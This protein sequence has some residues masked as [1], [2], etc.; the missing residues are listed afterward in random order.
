MSDVSVC[1]VCV[2]GMLILNVSW[3]GRTYVGALMDSTNHAWAPPRIKPL[4]SKSKNAALAGSAADTIGN[5]IGERKLRNGK[6]TYKANGLSTSAMSVTT[7][8][9]AEV[10]AASRTASQS[11]MSVESTSSP[12]TPP[13]ATGTGFAALASHGQ[14]H[15][16]GHGQANC[17]GAA[18]AAAAAAAGA[19]M[20][21]DLK[22]EL[23]QCTENGCFKKFKGADGLEY[24]RNYAHGVRRL[25]AASASN[26][27]S[28]NAQR[29][30]SPP[31]A[32]CADVTSRRI[33]G[34]G[35]EASDV[36]SGGHGHS[37][38]DH[39]AAATPDRSAGPCGPGDRATSTNYSGCSGLD[40][41]TDSEGRTVDGVPHTFTSNPNKAFASSS[42]ALP[43]HSANNGTKSPLTGGITFKVG[44][45]DGPIAAAGG[46]HAKH[47]ELIGNGGG[48]V[49]S[50]KD[51]KHH[52]DNKKSKSHSD[53]EQQ[54][55]NTSSKHNNKPSAADAAAQFQ[56]LQLVKQE[57]MQIDEQKMPLSL[58]AAAIAASSSS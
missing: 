10:K 22:A 50:S 51:N 28:G 17:N 25:N 13:A 19:G 42:S 55:S 29:V 7:S 24:H 35:G 23:L 20:G 47:R 53:S 21:V 11:S 40:D 18:D 52:K 15:N 57:V 16:K 6:V 33:R 48:R 44:R 12:S 8:P 26:S 2:T 27:S 43:L 1:G 46:H 32:G 58:S 14:G 56:Q 4:N 38:V 41:K 45:S 3:R 30:S 37:I 39:G 49:K 54:Q 34:G 9:A 5:N 36:I 31:A